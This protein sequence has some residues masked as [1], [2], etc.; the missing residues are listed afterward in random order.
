VFQASADGFSPS[1]GRPWKHSNEVNLDGLLAAQIMEI[2]GLMITVKDT[3]KYVA[4][5]AGSIHKTAPDSPETHAIETAGVNIRIG[6][7]PSVIMALRAICDVVVRGCEP[8]YE[9]LRA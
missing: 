1:L 3:V 9:A 4:N 6:G 2:D 8:L 7:H 5:Y